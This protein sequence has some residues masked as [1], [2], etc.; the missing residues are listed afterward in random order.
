[1]PQGGKTTGVQQQ[2]ATNRWNTVRF[3]ISTEE[4]PAYRGCPRTPLV[5]PPTVL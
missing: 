4:P 3:D 5:D 2:A 1:M